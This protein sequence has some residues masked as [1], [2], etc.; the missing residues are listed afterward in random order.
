MR[1]LQSTE[2]VLPGAAVP[3][4]H[5]VICDAARQQ[6]CKEWIAMRGI[7]RMVKDNDTAKK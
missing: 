3:T 6:S 4:S 2:V 1:I 5:H 7:Q